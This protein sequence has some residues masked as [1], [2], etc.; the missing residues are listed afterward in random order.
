MDFSR[1]NQRVF[2]GEIG[3]VLCGGTHLVEV[4]FGLCRR[5]FGEFP[6]SILFAMC[7]IRKAGQGLCWMHQANHARRPGRCTVC[8]LGLTESI[9]TD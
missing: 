3:R 2:F 4:L 5:L 7:L 9:H 1:I 6:G 8:T